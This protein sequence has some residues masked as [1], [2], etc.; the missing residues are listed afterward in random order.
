MDN[1]QISD[2][3]NVRL[4]CID[5]AIAA[6]TPPD[7]LVP[8]AESIL[9]FLKPKVE[10]AKKDDLEHSSNLARPTAKFLAAM[11]GYDKSGKKVHVTNIGKEQRLNA[12]QVA[13]ILSTLEQRKY[14]ERPTKQRFKILLTP[15]GTTYTDQQDEIF[16][17]RGPNNQAKVTFNGPE[18]TKFKLKEAAN[19]RHYA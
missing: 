8:L 5:K 1:A 13:Q 17:K 11:I 10:E 7:N 3:Y 15:Q 18:V 4:L 2:D 16:D 19:I 9:S 12:T 6:G 14:I